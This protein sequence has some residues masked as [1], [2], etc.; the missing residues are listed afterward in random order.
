MIEITV[1]VAIAVIIGAIAVPV[2]SSAL[3]SYQSRSA[4]SSLA[5]AIQSTR[6]RAIAAGYPYQIVFSAA[7]S[8]YLIQSDPNATG[9]FANVQAPENPGPFSLTGSSVAATLPGDVTLSFSPSGS[10]RA[11]TG[12][13][14]F[15][16][17]CGLALTFKNVV[18]NITVTQYG[19]ISINP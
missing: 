4:A 18:E 7:N 15:N 12:G 3:T 16:C 13:T 5:G 8:N 1:V 9:T 11:T 19:T 6:Y 10:V 17:P 14:T 2:I